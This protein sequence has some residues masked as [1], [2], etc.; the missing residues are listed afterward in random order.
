LRWRFIV[1][2]YEEEYSQRH[3]EGSG[4]SMA[5]L[6]EERGEEPGDQE[7]KRAKGKAGKGLRQP[8]QLD[9]IGKS[10]WGKGR[11]ALGPES[12]G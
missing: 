2:R 4:V 9:Y 6:C 7:N 8:N 11:W 3:L 5:R 1:D 12:S 10:S